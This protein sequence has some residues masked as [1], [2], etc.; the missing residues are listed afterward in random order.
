[1]PRVPPPEPLYEHRPGVWIKPSWL[2]FYGATLQTRMCV[3]KVEDAVLLYSPTPAQPDEAL[4]AEIRAYGEPRWLVAPNEIHNIGLSGFQAA[5]PNVHTTGCIGHPERVPKV[6]FDLLL[7]TTT[8][9]GT[10]PWAQ[11]GEVRFHVIGGNSFLHEIAL[12]HVPSRTLLVADA[13]E[14]FVEGD[15]TFQ[16]PPSLVTWMFQKTGITLNQP[17][18]SPEHNLCCEDPDALA[19]SLELLASWDFDS[20]VMSHGRI[21]SGTEARQSLIDAFQFNIDRARKR[22]KIVRKTWRLLTRLG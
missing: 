5:L 20:L 3:V 10:V 21:I 19:A 12:L 9:A 2:R 11:S 22:S 16:T 7:D 13:I 8:P 6:H 1:M 18:M 4:L 14:Y 17:C 15:P